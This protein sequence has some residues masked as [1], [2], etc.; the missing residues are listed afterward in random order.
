MGGEEPSE[1]ISDHSMPLKSEHQTNKR[2]GQIN[3]LI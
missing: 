3:T 1:R 2:P